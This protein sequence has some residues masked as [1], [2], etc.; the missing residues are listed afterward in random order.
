MRT[1]IYIISTVCLSDVTI[2]PGQWSFEYDV[3]Y[4]R[5]LLDPSVVHESRNVRSRAIGKAIGIVAACQQ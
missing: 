2:D 4:S 1:T 3:N 5:Q